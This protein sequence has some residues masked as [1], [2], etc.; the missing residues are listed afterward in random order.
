[1][2]W[3]TTKGQSR[4]EAAMR[5]IKRDTLSQGSILARM[6]AADVARETLGRPFSWEA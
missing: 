3:T 4:W 6:V 2:N 5:Q 1:M